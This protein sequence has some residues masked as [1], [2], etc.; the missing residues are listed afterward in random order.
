MACGTGL[1]GLTTCTCTHKDSTEKKRQ[2]LDESDVNAKGRGQQT[3]GSHVGCLTLI[4]CFQGFPSY[5][6]GTL[7]VFFTPLR[8]SAQLVWIKFAVRLAHFT[9]SVF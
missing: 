1:V 7:G 6:S 4:R 3:Y 2:V 8:H 9:V 5:G